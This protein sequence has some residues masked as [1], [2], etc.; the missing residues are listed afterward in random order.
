MVSTCCSSLQQSLTSKNSQV[1]SLS[2][3]LSDLKK[4][5]SLQHNKFMQ[6]LLQ[7]RKELQEKIERLEQTLYKVHAVVREPANLEDLQHRI[8]VLETQVPVPPYYFTVSM[9]HSGLVQPSFPVL[10]VTKWP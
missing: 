5:I 10:V 7:Q 1:T 2:T 9:V 8:M 4:E 6:M 3:E